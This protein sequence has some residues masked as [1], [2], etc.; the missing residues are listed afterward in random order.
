M[1]RIYLSYV[2]TSLFRIYYEVCK[3][4]FILSLV[5]VWVYLLLRASELFVIPALHPIFSP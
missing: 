5:S 3:P 2:Y 1:S 4:Y